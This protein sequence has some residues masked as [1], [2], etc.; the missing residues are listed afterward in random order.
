MAPKSRFDKEGASTDEDDY[1]EGGGPS[2]SNPYYHLILLAADELGYKNLIK[3]ISIANMEGF[4]YKPRIDKEVLQRYS[5]GIIGLSGCLRGEIPYLLNLGYEK[6]AQAAAN[7]YLE[8]F[9][10]DRFYIE[11]QDNGLEL[12]RSVN[13]KLIPLAIKNNIPIVATN[14]CHYLHKEDARAHDIMLCIQTGKTVNAQHRM[15]FQTDQLYFKSSEEMSAAFSEIPEAVKNTVAIAEQINLDLKFGKLHL[16]NYTPPFGMT[17]EDYLK[18]LAE[19]GLQ[20]R[21]SEKKSTFAQKIYEDRLS[22]EL[23]VIRNVE[24]AGYFLIVW[25]IINH[26]K[27]NKIPVGPGRGSAAGS[28]VAYA[29]GITD[30][31]P[32]TYGLLFERFL[33]S[34]RISP[35]DIDMDIS[36]DHR[37][38]LINYVKNKFGEDHVCQIITFGTMAAKAAIRDVGRVLEIPYGEVD[39]IAKLVPNTLNITLD[40]ALKQEPKLRQIAEDPERS[41]L[42]TLAKNMEGLVRHASTHAAGVVISAEPLTEYLPLYR[43]SHGE[44]ITQYAMGD[45]EKIGLVKFDFLGLRT[46]TVIDHAVRLVTALQATPFQL[47]EIPIDDTKTYTDLGVGETIGIFQLESTGMRDLLVKMKPTE[48]EDIIA[49]L[50]LYR[51]GPI[52]SGMTNDFVRGKKGKTKIHYEL[53][54]LEPILKETYGVILYQEQVMKIANVLAGFSLGE[55]DLLRRAMGK[56]KA[57]EMAAQKSLFMSRSIENGIAEKKA[58]KIFDLMEYFAGYGFNKSHSA[59]Y[60]LI[61]YQTAYLKSHFPNQFMAALLTSEKGNSDKIVRYITECRRMGILILPPDINESEIDFTAVTQS[62]R[63]GLAAIKNVGAAA[64]EVIIAARAATGKFLSLLHFC[65]VVSLRKVNKRVIEGLIKSGA[66][67][68]TKIRRSLLI[69]D[70]E[71]VMQAAEKSK[72]SSGSNQ[73]SLFGEEEM[74]VSGKVEETGAAH[75]VTPADADE[76][77]KMEKESLGFYITAHPLARYEALMK[78]R[79]ITPTELLQNNDEDDDAEGGTNSVLTGDRFISVAGIVT[80]ERVVQTKK[81][82]KMSYLR[83]EDLTGSIEVILFPDLYR[84]AAPLV[85]MDKPIVITGTADRT[86]HGVK[87][88]ATRVSLLEEGINRR[89]TELSEP[90]PALSPSTMVSDIMPVGV[91]IGVE[92]ESVA[93]LVIIFSSENE[94]PSKMITLKE[95]LGRSP[96]TTPVLLQFKTKEQSMVIDIKTKVSASPLLTAKIE[97]LFE[98]AKVE[99]R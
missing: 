70:L 31:D 48:F 29:L 68:F 79:N 26:A 25:D 45:V 14:D 1:S 17:R 41:E 49:L 85:K 13:K 50:A 71:S 59:A 52:G 60:A 16:P 90:T 89:E 10:K 74:P 81:G 64:V 28:L 72:K 43:G 67:D 82:D 96:G 8:I 83:L 92:K 94:V 66:F 55:A 51:P 37:E 21:F 23:S 73:V 99:L 30:I 38:T 54:Q 69:E 9:G 12:Q 34:E 42:I 47:S 80:E 77:S 18:S 86:E 27:T 36:M 39:K 20:K 62:I 53:P 63:F 19:A 4:Y 84:T 78:Q 44:M 22:S 15:R 35:P 91:R 87:F 40:D 7:D 32:I 5:A 88:K 75:V 93:S 56:K 11:I 3:L 97:M 61:T 58:E 76:I 46:L 65:Q 57:D 33:N 2:G 95:I 24:Y 6:E 98:S